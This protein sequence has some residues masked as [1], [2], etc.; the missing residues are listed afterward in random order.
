MSPRPPITK[1]FGQRLRSLRRL[2]RLTQEELAD[3][4]GVSTKTISEI[5]RGVGNPTLDLV[6]RL[7]DRL[8]VETHELFLFEPLADAPTR[9]LSASAA[10][11]RVASYLSGLP[12]TEVARILRIVELILSNVPSV[13]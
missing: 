9:G 10:G 4:A 13:R 11:E 6:G 5:E 3:R 2:R 12:R 7:A 1:L 8:G